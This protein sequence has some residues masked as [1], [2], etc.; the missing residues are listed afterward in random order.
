M[1]ALE[2]I[3]TYVE[4]HV[5]M[6]RLVWNSIAQISDEQFLMDDAS[7]LGSIRD[8]MVHITS[9]DRRWLAVLKNQVDV[10]HLKS[11]DYPTREAAREVFESVAKDMEGYVRWLSE[12]ELERNATGMPWPRWTMLLHLINRGTELRAIV[13]QRLVEFGVS[14]FD[15]NFILWLRRQ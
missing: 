3:R 8:R 9:T 12:E 6:T 11:E 7:S 2:M 13:L 5:D 14:P 10:G 15:Q 4:Y 1:S